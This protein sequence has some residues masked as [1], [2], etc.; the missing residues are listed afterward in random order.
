MLKLRWRIIFNVNRTS[1]T[2][3]GWISRSCNPELVGCTQWMD[4]DARHTME[5]AEILSSKEPQ[6]GLL[7]NTV[8]IQL[9]VSLSQGPVMF[10]SLFPPPCPFWYSAL[11]S[12]M[13]TRQNVLFYIGVTSHEE[14]KI[15]VT[16]K[17]CECSTLI[18]S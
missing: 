15:N 12:N 16:W 5:I 4:W 6:V 2:S 1:W 18:R 8:L 17:R 7:K 13:F 10:F 3:I 11:S 9:R 14:N